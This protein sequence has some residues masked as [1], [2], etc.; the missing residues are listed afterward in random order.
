MEDEPIRAH[1]SG[2]Q[3]R[4]DATANRQRL[5]VV[6]R[7]LFAAQGIEGTSMNQIAQEAHVGSGTLYRH[8]AHKG[9][10]C[11]ALLGDDI[12]A[13][14][15][16]VVVIMGEPGAGGSALLRLE[17]FVGELI[18][19]TESHVPLMSAMQDA[20]AGMRRNNLYLSPFYVWSHAQISALLRT[21]IAQ[22]EVADRDL[23]VDFTADALI[24]AITPPLL[25]FQQQHRGFSRERIVAGV[26]RIFIAG[27][28]G[29]L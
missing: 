26:R 22:S 19:L 16:R 8:F 27:L 12:E 2:R 25:A 14:Q 11:L 6:A 21:A 7:Q 5:L 23:D 20:A 1:E 29:C 18:G 4:R 3:V 24:G 9:E 13:F 10:I 17:L 15:Q 28:R